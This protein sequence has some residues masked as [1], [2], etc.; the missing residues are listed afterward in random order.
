M[1]HVMYRILKLIGVVVCLWLL[2]AGGLAWSHRTYF[3]AAVNSYIAA[4]KIPAT[5]IKSRRITYNSQGGTNA[6]PWEEI[7]L[8]RAHHRLYEYDYQ[9]GWGVDHN[10]PTL[11]V[12]LNGNEIK[13]KQAPYQPLKYDQTAFEE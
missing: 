3:A 2:Y 1:K 4:Q 6:Y 12:L 13:A 9:M 5:A 11:S 7:V 10:L 8:V